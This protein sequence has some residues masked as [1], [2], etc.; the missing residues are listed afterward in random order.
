MNTNIVLV[1]KE[2][3]HMKYPLP[4]ECVGFY[5]GLLEFRFIL[6]DIVSKME[7]VVGIQ[8][9]Q[10]EQPLQYIAQPGY[11]MCDLSDFIG[12]IGEN[13]KTVSKNKILKKK[14]FNK[15]NKNCN[16]I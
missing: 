5:L 16:R 3:L 8:K 7:S 4:T 13:M 1:L 11:L 15:K 9:F 6:T 10:T 12:T 2:K 14:K